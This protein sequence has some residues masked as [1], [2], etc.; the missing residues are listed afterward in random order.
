[1]SATDNKAIVRRY[2]ALWERGDGAIADEI[3]APT[4]CD[5]SHPEW[6]PGTAG[7]KANLRDFH[8]AFSDVRVEVRQ[9]IGEGDLVAL[10]FQLGATHVG[11]FGR[12]PPTGK[13]VMYA[14]VDIARLAGGQ[15][16]ELWSSAD[17]LNWVRQLG[18]TVTLCEG[19]AVLG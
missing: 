17:M 9:L 3:L 19:D 12:F 8:A 10:H 5:H 11:Y 16:V 7:L 15:M 1:M 4:Y 18:A 13:R 6:P 2:I 14:G